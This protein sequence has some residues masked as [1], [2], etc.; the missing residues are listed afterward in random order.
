L[1]QKSEKS[2]EIK[3][4]KESVAMEKTPERPHEIKAAPAMQQ[5]AMSRTPKEV[6]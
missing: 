3:E 6:D 5:S 4:K 1:Q 2:V